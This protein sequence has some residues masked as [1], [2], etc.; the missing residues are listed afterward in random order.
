MS[1]ALSNSKRKLFWGMF[2]D[3]RKG[4]GHNAA[5]Y[6]RYS[7]NYNCTDRLPQI[8]LPVLLLYGEKDTGFHS[9]GRLLHRYVPQDEL[10]FI[11]HDELQRMRRV[12]RR[13]EKENTGHNN[14]EPLGENR[15][16][17]R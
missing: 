14:S 6:Y 11:R 7:L 1:L 3:A 4:R 9:Y 15:L 13:L 8:R 16:V 2:N 12:C 10:D 5:Q 17:F